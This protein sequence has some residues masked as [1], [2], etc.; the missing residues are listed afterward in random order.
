MNKYHLFFLITALL[1]I[2]L[3][4]R[5]S[6]A[7]VSPSRVGQDTLNSTLSA[8]GVVTGKNLALSAALSPEHTT[9]L[10]LLK[11]AGLIQQAAGKDAY[12]VFAPTNAAFTD[13]PDHLLSELLLPSSH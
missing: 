13:L 10:Q 3:P 11:A 12:T 9:L 1:M 7:Q 2:T 6:R 8:S 5:Q 4:V